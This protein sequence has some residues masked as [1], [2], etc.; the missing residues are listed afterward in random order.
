[1]GKLIIAHDLGTTGNKATLFSEEGEK[2]ASEFFGYDT[3]F[4]DALSVEQNA[5]D[6]WEAVVCSTRRLLEKGKVKKEDIGV[7][8]FSGQMMGALPV[9]KNGQPLYHILIWADRRGV[10]EVEWIKERIGED[11]IYQLTG[12]RLSANYSLAKILWFRNHLP[13]IYNKAHK[14]LLAKDFV[15][16]RLTVS[17]QPTF[18]MLQEP[19][20]LIW[21]GKPGQRRYWRK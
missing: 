10:E 19:I 20:F 11:R 7:I 18:P 2:I 6:Y 5:E 21:L 15:V 1:M 8:S 3:Y 17:G 4:P 13:E 16:F 12:H 14:F 9:D